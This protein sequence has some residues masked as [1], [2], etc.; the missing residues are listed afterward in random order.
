MHKHSIKSNLN[1]ST[2]LIC[3]KSI[4]KVNVLIIPLVASMRQTRQPQPPRLSFHIFSF[5]SLTILSEMSG[6]PKFGPQGSPRLISDPGYRP[7]NAQLDYVGP[8][9]DDGLDVSCLLDNASL[10]ISE[11]PQEQMCACYCSACCVCMS[12]V[13][14]HSRAYYTLY[15]RQHIH[16]RAEQQT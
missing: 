11:Y 1:F 13:C 10:V 16:G 9:S 2:L 15:T 8:A 6:F 12:R 4:I 3:P 5:S 14:M 7:V